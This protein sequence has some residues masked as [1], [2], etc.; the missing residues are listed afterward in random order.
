[1]N[2]SSVTL[3]ASGNSLGAYIPA[4]HLHTY[5]QGRGVGSDV[6]VLENVYHEE[7]R[8]KIRAT[9]KAFHAD[10]SVARMGHKLARPVDTSLN[11]EAVL[12]LLE[13]WMRAGVTRFAVFTGFWLPILERY[14][15]AAGKPLDIRLI[16]LDAWD[17][18]SFK[19]HKQLYPGYDNVWFYVPSELSPGAYIAS[20]EAEPLPYGQRAGRILIHG[21][22]WGIGTYAETI[23][24][25]RGL[26][27]RL[28]VIV[29]DPS[30]VEEDDGVTRY[31]GTDA[32]WDPWSRDAQ[33]RHTFP[34]M[35]RY[36]REQ[37]VLREYPLRDY[38]AYTD[39]MRDCSAIISKPGGATLNDSLS[40]G[41]PFVMLEPFGDHELHNSAY[42]E[43][44]GFGIRFA[45]WQARNF[46]E[47]LLEGICTRLLE[48]RSKIKHFGRIT[49]AAENSSYV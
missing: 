43:S 46:S 36:V 42:W 7:V 38:S 16:R 26:G 21:G 23:R 45:E 49:Y 11:E 4:M 41:I 3:L 30:E 29:Y 18:P 15:A 17:T 6:H 40:F 14:K 34:P 27:R 13:D 25:L 10:F 31:F 39:L 22:G 47:H 48:Q 2:S 35:V 28:D 32:S 19:V 9:K 8:D 44:C 12:R 20:D 1:M 37:G 33:G 5:L 24:E